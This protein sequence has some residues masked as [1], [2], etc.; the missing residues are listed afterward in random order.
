[1]K[2]A[3]INSS[4]N[5]G[6]STISRE[7]VYSRIPEPKIIVEV[8]GQNSSSSRFQSITSIKHDGSTDFNVFYEYIINDDQNVIF[9][10]GAS[11]IANFVTSISEYG[12]LGMFDLFIVPT[13]ADAKIMEDTIKTIKFLQSQNIENDK[14]KVVFNAV[15]KDVKTDFA[16]LLAF[17][18]DYEFNEDCFVRES[19]IISDLSLLKM[20]LIDVYNPDKKFYRD[21]LLSETDP[22]KKKRLLKLDLINQAADKKIKE[23]DSV[24]TA[25]T[26]EVIDTV[27]SF[28]F[29]PADKKQSKQD[30]PKV[31]E[32]EDED[33]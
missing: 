3:I 4:G 31:E 15:K 16:P 22:Q 8:E 6:K 12:V 11:E 25:I 21:D 9:D 26:G 18:F 23:F 32:Q 14:I 5:V 20:T 7:L 13:K 28:S 1:M 30:K 29:S 24:W 27:S 33:L 10:I 17:K 19:N 2:I